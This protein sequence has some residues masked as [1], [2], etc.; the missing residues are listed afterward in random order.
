M[1]TGGGEAVLQ[2][3][4]RPGDWAHGSG[5]GRR[6]IKVEIR[7]QSGR[8]DVEK[9]KRQRGKGEGGEGARRLGSCSLALAPK[10]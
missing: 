10:P 7:R 9:G 5:R 3:P 8:R 4:R 1:Q 6:E 2:G